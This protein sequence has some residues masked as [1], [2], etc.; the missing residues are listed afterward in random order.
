MN[1]IIRWFAYKCMASIDLSLEDLNDSIS[2][3]I[4]QFAETEKL[5]S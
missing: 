1:Y 3:C 2:F 5:I 4:F